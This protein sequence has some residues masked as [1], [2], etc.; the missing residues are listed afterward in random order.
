MTADQRE[1]LWGAVVALFWLM[2]LAGNGVAIGFAWGRHEAR[3][4]E[5]IGRAPPQSLGAR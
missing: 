1:G 2:M 5:C 4:D 3:N